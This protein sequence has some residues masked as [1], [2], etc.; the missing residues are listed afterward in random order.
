MALL[1]SCWPVCRWDILHGFFARG[2][3]QTKMRVAV[4]MPWSG[5]SCV[6]PGLLLAGVRAL[7]TRESKTD[8]PKRKEPML[9]EILA[10]GLLRYGTS[11]Y[12]DHNS[13]QLFW[14]ERCTAPTP[15][16][17]FQW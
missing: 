7:S 12:S 2:G 14:A 6:L 17:G 1:S 13:M 15:F 10:Q 8:D 9:Y 16:M 4:E 3:L 5:R 11:N